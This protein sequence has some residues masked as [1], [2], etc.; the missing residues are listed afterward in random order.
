MQNP[1]VEYP[2]DPAQL[3][4]GRE[5]SV[6]EMLEEERQ[7]EERLKR[8]QMEMERRNAEA[9][10]HAAPRQEEQEEARPRSAWELAQ[11]AINRQTG[12]GEDHASRSAWEL[13]QD[14]VNQD[15]KA[16]EKEPYIPKVVDETRRVNLRRS[17]RQRRSDAPRKKKKKS[18]RSRNRRRD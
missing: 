12:A 6:T 5:K 13:A 10:Y 3:R 2:F 11:D 9:G 8:E 17:W 1:Q 18:W 16:H 15:E 14:A 4:Y 7:E